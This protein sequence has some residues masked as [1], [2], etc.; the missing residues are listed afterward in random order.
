MNPLVTQFAPLLPGLTEQSRTASSGGMRL[1]QRAITEALLYAA[2]NPSSGPTPDIKI[3]GYQF[4]FLNGDDTTGEP[5]SLTKPFASVRKALSVIDPGDVVFVGPGTFDDADPTPFS[6]AGAFSVVGCGTTATRLVFHVSGAFLILG[7]PGQAA[8]ATLSNL[9]IENA[10]PSGG[11][12]TYD[13]IKTITPDNPVSTLR[14]SHIVFGPAGALPS[15]ATVDCTN[16][17]LYLQDGAVVPYIRRT[18]Y[19]GA[20]PALYSNVLEVQAGAFVQRLET[21][22]VPELSVR[23]GA[24]VGQLLSY[25]DAASSALR[26]LTVEPTAIVRYAS[27]IEL[28]RAEC[29]ALLSGVFDSMYLGMGYGGGGS[30][31]SLRHARIG[32]IEINPPS[33][34]DG[35]PVLAPDCLID[36]VLVSQ[37]GPGRFILDIRGGG[38]ITTSWISGGNNAYL[39]RDYAVLATS[40]GPS[41]MLT[42]IY[43]E[44]PPYVGYAYTVITT[45]NDNVAS[46]SAVAVASKSNGTFL[47]FAAANTG[48]YAYIVRHP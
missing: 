6:V 3:K 14:L 31:V 23:A 44:F 37:T 29:A 9:Y 46:A 19:G 2:A 47:S 18:D 42:S 45:C 4:V 28:P 8:N 34:F 15:Y 32:T 36:T 25:Q 12:S 10:G 5:N 43:P 33:G 13:C 21:A 26:K 30:T 17:D 11:M 48:I 7:L 1:W 40:A 24:V 22:S 20:F 27:P 41:G 39:D 16:I 35:A 38:R